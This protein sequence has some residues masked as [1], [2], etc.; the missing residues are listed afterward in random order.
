MTAMNVDAIADADC[1]ESIAV[2]GAECGE[3]ESLH[4][5]HWLGFSL[6]GEAE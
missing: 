5:F 4:Q 6:F 3:G 2:L 1:D